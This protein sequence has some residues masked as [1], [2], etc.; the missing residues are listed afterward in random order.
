M[1]KRSCA[2]SCWLDFIFLPDLALAQASPFLTGANALQTN[3]LAWLTP[4][5]VI[6]VIALEEA[7][8]EAIERLG[9]NLG[10][11]VTALESLKGGLVQCVHVEGRNVWTFK[12]PT[13][14]DAF[15]SLLLENSELLGI[16]VRGTS[17]DRLLAQVTCGEVD[18]ERSVTLP[19]SL[20][21]AVLDKIDGAVETTQY[22]TPYLASW[23]T[24]DRVD[25]FLSF[26][27]SKDFLTLYL[28]RH[29]ETLDRVCK[30]G[31]MLSSG[32]G[33]SPS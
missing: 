1:Q 16:Y 29:P 8:R 25:S 26:R 30:P 15:A 32:S 2:A 4:I 6:L 10:V 17:V 27:C 23:Y 9:S 12:H 5:A 22:K 18:L 14:A 28:Q 11:C 31:L 19:K 13:V 3:I 24:K 20:F 7:T 21:A 33:D